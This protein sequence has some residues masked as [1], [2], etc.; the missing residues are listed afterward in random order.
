[1]KITKL[2][3]ASIAAALALLTSSA[4]ANPLLQL[5]IKDATYDLSSETIMASSN[6]FSL[7]AYGLSS[8][9]KVV[10]LSDTFFISMALVPPTSVPANYGSFTINGS[11]INVTADMSY[12][13]PPLEAYLA[14]DSGDLSKHSIF[15]TYFTEVS[16]QFSAAAQSAAYN[17]QD[18]FGS[19][20]IAGTGMYYKKFDFDISGLAAGY[21]IH[22][23]LYNEKIKSGGDIDVYKFAPFSHDAAGMVTAIP[24]PEIY[25]MMGVGLG[26]MGWAAR[27]R[28][29][30]VA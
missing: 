1:M 16:F 11:T 14:F 13:T 23:D 22:F 26:L 24:E 15:P 8:G 3:V 7:Y 17:T 9:S 10:S 2:A 29:Q 20:P 21:G 6:T 18:D 19:G 27:R 12:G 30:Q 28:K 4:S 25:A 5:D